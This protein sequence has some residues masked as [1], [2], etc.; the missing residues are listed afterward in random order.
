MPNSNNITAP[1]TVISMPRSGST[2]VSAIFDQHPQVHSVGETANLIFDSWNAVEFSRGVLRPSFNQDGKLLETSEKAAGVIQQTFISLFKSPIDA[3]F[4]KPI[5]IPKILWQ[6]FDD[7]EWAEA[8][9]WYWEVMLNAFPESKYFTLLRHPC[10]VVLSTEKHLGFEQASTWRQLAFMAYIL[11]YPTAP[12]DYAIHYEQLVNNK[13][14]TTKDLFDYLELPFN[15]KVLE[16]FKEVHIGSKGR[17]D[18]GS[19]SSTRKDEWQEID[20]TAVTRSQLTLIEN[21][22]NKF[23]YPISWPEQLTELEESDQNVDCSLNGSPSTEDLLDSIEKLNSNIENIHMD[24]SVRLIKLNTEKWQAIK[25]KN[26]S[27]QELNKLRAK[28]AHLDNQINDIMNS[29]GG[30]ALQKYW[31]LADRVKGL[32]RKGPEPTGPHLNGVKTDTPP[33][34]TDTKVS[35]PLDAKEASKTVTFVLPAGFTLGGVTNWSIEMSK[36]LNLKKIPSALIKYRNIGPELALEHPLNTRLIKCDSP[37]IPVKAELLQFETE[38]RK[39]LPGTLIPNYNPRTY[40]IC[41]SIAKNEAHKIRLLGYAHTDEASYYAIL[42]FYE[43]LIHKFVAV[44]DEI[45]DKLKTL[46]PHRSGDILTKPYGVQVDETVKITKQNESTPLKL[47]YAGRIEQIQKR[48]LDFVD[49]VKALIDQ[50]VNFR[51]KIVG[52]GSMKEELQA[53][54]NELGPEAQRAVTFVEPLAPTAMPSL[55]EEADI[56]VL[57]SEYE[58]TSISLLEAM[59]KG[60]VPVV[61]EVSGVQRVIQSG[62]NGFTSPIGDMDKMASLIKSLDTDRDRLQSTG[63]NA[64]KTIYEQF[65]Y[66]EYVDWFASE[67][68]QIWELP[69]RSWNHDEPILINHKAMKTLEH[70]I[71]L[72]QNQINSDSPSSL[73]QLN[74]IK[75]YLFS[76]K[77]A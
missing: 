48:A 16:A 75:D 13:E 30:R 8:A 58:G 11:T 22:F 68:D 18:A 74:D 51:L 26:G 49:L 54:I 44:S 9:E 37:Q 57:V 20:S 60:C 42:F 36:R 71:T 77:V 5:G 73:T 6:K 70:S 34:T 62:K 41:A 50:D 59:S 32:L 4:H 69:P 35:P 24:Y 33:E 67:C 38:Y 15:A 55:W 53:G 3:W 64:H 28:T 46:M 17:R 39:V 56:C 65:N 43:K 1:I 21:L 63:T 7:T 31:M 14:E 2:L 72:F 25:N 66:D 40:A 29:R 10:D 12:V 52:D 23:G 27:T 19:I 47:V 45:A 76:G 61:T